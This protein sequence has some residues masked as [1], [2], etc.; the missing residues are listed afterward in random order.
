M[1]TPTRIVRDAVGAGRWFP[2]RQGELQAMVD[3]FIDDAA[4]PRIAGRIASAIAP[5]AGFV[6]SGAVA[7]ATFRALRDTA[8]EDPPDT[9]VV[10][11]FRHR[12]AFR[13]VA[14]MDGDA[15]ST[16]LGETPLDA[17]SVRD[18]AAHPSDRLFADYTPHRGEH[19]AENEIPFLQR[20][21][22]E[23]KL[24][25][26]LMG[27]HDGATIEALTAALAKLA[28]SRRIVVVA[29]S[30]MLHDPDYDLVT[31]TDQATLESVA[32]LDIAGVAR[33][34]SGRQQVFC[35][36]APVLTAMA[37]AAQT[38]C[39]SGTIL[40]YR[41]SGDDHPESR[42]EWV[43]GYGAVAFCYS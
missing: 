35:G 20:A 23:A 4:P 13:G 33:R 2:D 37:F 24:V 19:S 7:G 15:I 11:G 30:D 41:N 43:V 3:G 28:Q 12:E 10:L 18:L 25:V 1:R 32:R 16:P 8:R 38:G 22:P 36:I 31:R 29:S 5:H 26:G 40:S 34:W 17:A 6:Y 27:D 39:R 42:G 9:V 21:L 14:L